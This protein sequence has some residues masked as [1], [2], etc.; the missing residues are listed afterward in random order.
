MMKTQDL[1]IAAIAVGVVAIGAVCAYNYANSSYSPC[2]SSS[3]CNDAPAPSSD[4][5]ADDA[6]EDAPAQLRV[7]YAPVGDASESSPELEKLK[8]EAEKLLPKDASG[9]V[10]VPVD[11]RPTQFTFKSG[12]RG[13]YS[14]LD[15]RPAIPEPRNAQAIWTACNSF[16]VPESYTDENGNERL[17][18][19]V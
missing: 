16:N 15:N 13:S 8:A 14:N 19:Y 4:E 9:K 2:G 11:I 5:P 10:I 18:R 3:C 7:T 1:I 17:I 6:S 12:R